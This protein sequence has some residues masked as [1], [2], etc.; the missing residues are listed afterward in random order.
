MEAY[1]ALISAML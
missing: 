1:N